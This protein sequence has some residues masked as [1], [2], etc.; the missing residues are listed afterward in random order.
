MSCADNVVGTGLGLRSDGARMYK[1]GGPDV[2]TAVGNRG[3]LG[4]GANSSCPARSTGSDAARCPA[5][6]TLLLLGP[7][8]AARCVAPDLEA[9]PLPLLLPLVNG[10]ACCAMKLGSGKGLPPQDLLSIA[11]ARV[12]SVP[13]SR[14]PSS[15]LKVTARRKQVLVCQRAPCP[16]RCAQTLQPTQCD[17]SC[18]AH[19]RSMPCGKEASTL[20]L[21]ALHELDAHPN[22]ANRLVRGPHS[23]FHTHCKPLLKSSYAC[24]T[25]VPMHHTPC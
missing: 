1:R 4:L 9:T 10:V 17:P 18:A 22:G 19:S 5:S 12:L 6:A 14:P 7:Q 24:G 3:A 11:A 23:E 16:W 25:A 2:R 15:E 13:A 8:P 20:S 21:R